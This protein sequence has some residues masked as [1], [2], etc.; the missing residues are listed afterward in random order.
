MRSTRFVKGDFIAKGSFGRV[1]ASDMESDEGERQK[2]AIKKM[3]VA[4]TGIPTLIEPVIMSSVAHPHVA[5]C[6]DCRAQ[7]SALYIMQPLASS[8]LHAHRQYHDLPL[9]QLRDWAFSLVAAVDALHRARVIHCDIKCDNILV[10]DGQLRLADFSLACVQV[11][12]GQTFTH[13]VCTINFRPPENLLGKRW[14]PKL[15]VWS[16]GCSLFEM[17]YGKYLFASQV[18]HERNRKVEDEAGKIRVRQRSLMAVMSWGRFLQGRRPQTRLPSVAFSREDYTPVSIPAEFDAPELAVFNDLLFQMLQ[19]VPEDRISAKQ[20]L[21]HPFFTGLAA[22][23]GHLRV[24]L[25]RDLSAPETNRTARYFVRYTD[26]DERRPLV[27]TAARRLFSLCDAVKLAEPVKVAVCCWIAS[28]VYFGG[29]PEVLEKYEASKA[30]G[31]LSYTDPNPH[32][33][34]S[35][36][37]LVCNALG[38]CLLV[39]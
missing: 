14:G 31:L 36:E 16:L 27:Q 9:P 15:D 22:P 12:E 3:A 18:V 35:G 4:R 2:V 30:R 37:R 23:T 8:N 24:P 20:A 5:G 34:L 21:R 10:V 17:A 29:P 33:V 19:L 7:D 13:D 32:Q 38:F 26:D 1:Y 6:I 28:K 39:L 25:F 11:E